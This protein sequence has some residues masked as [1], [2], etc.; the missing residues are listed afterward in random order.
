MLPSDLLFSPWG[1]P[2]SAFIDKKTYKGWF[3]GAGERI[4]D[5]AS[6]PGLFWKTESRFFGAQASRPIPSGLRTRRAV[7]CASDD[8]KESSPHDPP[9]SWSTAS[10]GPARSPRRYSLSSEGSAMQ[11][12]PRRRRGAFFVAP[13]GGDIADCR[14]RRP[15]LLRWASARARSCTAARASLA[16]VRGET[17]CANCF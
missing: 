14:R 5:E 16:S 8:S 12:E 3:L 9:A 11:E 2:T 7:R 6:L 17:P 13:A 10:T 1:S 15:L 4:C